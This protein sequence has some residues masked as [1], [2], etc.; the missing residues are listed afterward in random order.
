M[1]SLKY[2]KVAETRERRA[3]N[4]RE[5][6][7]GKRDTK[8]GMAQALSVPEDSLELICPPEDRGVEYSDKGD[9]GSLGDVLGGLKL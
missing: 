6:L 5:R 3:E 8:R 1:A 4:K 2:F 7:A 9:F